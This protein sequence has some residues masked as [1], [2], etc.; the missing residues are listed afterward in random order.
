MHTNHRVLIGW[1]LSLLTSIL[2]SHPPTIADYPRT[3]ALAICRTDPDYFQVANGQPVVLIGDYTWGTFSQENY[4]YQGMFDTLK[5]NGL[6]LARIWVWCG[7]EKGLK[8][9]VYMS[10]FLRT[11]PGLANDGLPKYDLTRFNPVF[12]ERLSQVC[13]A[14][15]RRGIYLQLTLIDCWMIKHAFLWKMHACNRANNINR[16]DGD[17]DKT[18]RGTDSKR[19]FCSLGNHGT[20]AVQEAFIRKVIDTINPFDNVFIEIANE[21]FYNS[22]WE[23]SLCQYVHQY[24]KNMPNHHLVMPMDLPDHSYGGIQSWDLDI[25]HA[26]LMKDKSLDKPLIFD[27]DG[28]GH[29]GYPDDATI[30]KAAWTAFVSGGNVDYLD[31]S[32]QTGSEFHGDVQ[33]SRRIRL[34]RQLGNLARFTRQVRFWDM[35]ASNGLVKEGRAFAMASLQQMVVYLPDGGNVQ[36]D[37]ERLKGKLIARWFNPISGVWVNAN[38]ISSTSPRFTSPGDNDWVLFIK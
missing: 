15:R 24:E 1:I 28:M 6:N 12:F 5:S 30:R 10:P 21:N 11:G 17:P 27:T 18:G 19:G 8:N 22:Q 32:L 25:L 37:A 36:L 26:N 4:N 16:V 2:I 20:L 13:Q 34:R 14:A 7:E 3:G 23:L 33:G 35:R 31:Q 29:N 9:Y 38:S